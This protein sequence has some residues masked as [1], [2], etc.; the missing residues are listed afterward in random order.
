[1]PGS[2][3]SHLGGTAELPAG[4]P[5]PS[6]ALIAQLYLEELAPFDR[7]GLL[8]RS[9][10][11]VFFYDDEE[12]PWG[13]DPADRDGASAVF[14]PDGAPTEAT[15]DA[16]FHELLLEPI[17]DLTV[18]PLGSPQ[19]EPLGLNE[20]EVDAY[21]DLLSDLE[22]ELSDRCLGYPDEIQ[23]DMQL[24]AQLVTHG[25]YVG[26]PSGYEG[27][28]AEELA[29]GAADWRLLLQVDSHEEI[30]MCWG[31]LGRIYYW[32]TEEDLR[33]GAFGASWLI[34]QCT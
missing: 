5:R 30:G 14:V 16:Q 28:R 4:T 20:S 23:G 13:F 2:G 19:L 17:A 33:R 26:D 6:L 27:P 12:Q 21:I 9:G 24:E 31:D 15:S 25:I 7:E 32:I 8:P 22:G 18:P 11:I 29:P 10:S 3:R 34:L 1:V